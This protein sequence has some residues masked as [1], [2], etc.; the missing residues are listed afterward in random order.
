MS[1]QTD[2]IKKILDEAIKFHGHLGPFLVLGLKAGLF[3][4]EVLGKDYFR[5]KATVETEPRPPYSCF[6]D[7]I[8][9][10]T[11]CTMGKCN[12]KIKRGNPISLTI[13]RN[14]RVLIM[15]LKEEVLDF[16]VKMPSRKVVE[17]KAFEIMNKP[18]N[19]LFDI[20]YNNE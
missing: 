11:G 7:G 13:S 16:L 1:N 4:N 2:K 15:K 20:T 19:E 17:Q 6:V 9:I 10:A 8:Q 14:G 12:I 3:A 18:I 5:T